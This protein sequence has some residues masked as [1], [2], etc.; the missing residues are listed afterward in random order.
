M[1][2][3]RTDQEH[4]LTVSRRPHGD[5]LWC[6]SLDLQRDVQYL[7]F[8]RSQPDQGIV[9]GHEDPGSAAIQGG[10]NPAKPTVIFLHGFGERAYS[11]SSMGIKNGTTKLYTIF[12]K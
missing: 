2:M 7:L 10:A 4:E 9:L 1:Y 5:C 8:T 6:C 12:N 11:F 3:F